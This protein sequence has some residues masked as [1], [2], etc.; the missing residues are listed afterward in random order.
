MKLSLEVPKSAKTHIKAILFPILYTILLFGIALLIYFYANGYRIDVFNQSIVQTGVINV[1]SDV[2]GAELSL[3]GKIIGRTPKSSSLDIGEYDIKVQKDGYYVWQKQ[4][5]VIEGKSTLVYA[6]LIKDHPGSNVAWT[7]S[8]TI[9]KYWT[10]S[11]KNMILFLTQENGSYTLWKYNVNPTLWDFSSNP[12]EIMTFE[13]DKLDIL[14][15]PNGLQALLTIA[16]ETFTQYYIINTQNFSTLANEKPLSILA[17]KGYSISW[18]NDN[19]YIVL[20][21]KTNISTYNIKTNKVLDL[22]T[23]VST[24]SYLW[25][26]DTTG[27]FYILEPA[28][29]SDDKTNLY[30]LKQ[31]NPDTTENKYIIESFYFQKTD[32]YIKEYREKGFPYQEFTTSPESTFSAGLITNFNVNQDA[33]GVYI[34]TSLATYWFN[35]ETQK[36]IMI[37]AYPA[38]L[39]GISPDSEK[40]VFK[41]EKQIGVFTFYKKEGDHTTSIGSKTMKNIEDISKVS[42]LSWISNSTYISYKENDDIYIADKE[43]DNKSYIAKPDNYLNHVIKNSRNSLVTFSK[44]SENKLQITEYFIR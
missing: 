5:S 16:T 18:S 27:F 38:E 41:D 15:S 14:L 19:S 39:I 44:N 30:R 33:Q 25:T 20:E 23:K 12:M 17:T 21:N 35:M 22:I 37:S 1:E 29:S 6:W 26:T 24:E 7:S 11:E 36:F 32:E 13:N 9:I 42:D 2:L 28:V 43:G 4:A 3:N 40:L 8:G 10:N 31:I 34:T